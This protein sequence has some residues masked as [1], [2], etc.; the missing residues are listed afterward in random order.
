MIFLN[1]ESKESEAVT[2]QY[3]LNVTELLSM[4]PT[5]EKS[6]SF[7]QQI[8]D[9]ERLILRYNTAIRT[10]IQKYTASASDSATF[11]KSVEKQSIKRQLHPSMLP[12]PTWSK[13]ENL[14]HTRRDIHNKFFTIRMH[15][16]CQFSRECDIIGPTM[17]SYDIC[18]CVKKMHDEH[19]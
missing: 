3:K 17:T 2:T 12:P 9:I 13:M 18:M 5:I 4:L 10:L 7:Q 15:Q 6:P 11:Q 19:K 1:D 16:L 14:F 8:F